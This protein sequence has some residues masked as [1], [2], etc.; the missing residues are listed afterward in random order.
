[1]RWCARAGSNLGKIPAPA[2]AAGKP[3]SSSRTFSDERLDNRSLI[4]A[5]APRASFQGDL[6]EI[7]GA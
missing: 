2:L 5:P 4:H 6:G 7:N 1:V 3:R